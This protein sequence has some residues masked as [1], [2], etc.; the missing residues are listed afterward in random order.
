MGEIWEKVVKYPFFQC[1]MDL[2]MIL[3]TVLTVIN[4]LLLL[5]LI[6]V[7]AKNVSK[8]RSS[9]TFGLLLFAVIFIL[10][11]VLYLYF[12]LT[13]MTLYSVEAEI[14]VFVLTILQTVAFSILNII[15]WR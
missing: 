15:T 7:Y 11:H 4:L 5:A 2:I 13:M 9:F 6:F 14:F 8:I 1:F 3:S 10:Q 12:N